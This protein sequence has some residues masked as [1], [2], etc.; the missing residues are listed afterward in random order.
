MMSLTPFSISSIFFLS[1]V[2][3]AQMD[4]AH[5]EK[6]IMNTQA[7]PVADSR[8]PR[9]K[10]KIVLPVPPDLRGL[11]MEQP[12]ARYLVQVSEEGF[13]TEALCLEAT[14]FDLVAPGMSKVLQAEFSP[15]LNLGIPVSVAGMILVRFYDPEQEAWRSGVDYTPFGSNV[16]VGTERWMYNISRDSYTY[17]ETK[18]DDLDDLLILLEGEI[19]V[20][21]DDQGNKAAGECLVEFYIGPT[22]KVLFPR[23]IQ[24]DGE[25][26][27]MSAIMSLKKFRYQPPT[28]DGRETYVQVRQTFRFTE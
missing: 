9:L 23:I 13:V 20:L 6:E 5:S 19:V 18:I 14:H 1:T 2:I 24:S 15:A 7:A 26:V 17:S 3:W 22:G 27:S 21:S 8:H 28:R 11:L 16:S 10:D 12:Q 4:G 25:L